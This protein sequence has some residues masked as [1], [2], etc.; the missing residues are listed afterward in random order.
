MSNRYLS[1]PV[2]LEDEYKLPK[3]AALCGSGSRIKSGD[4]R[5]VTC[6]RCMEI[7]KKGGLQL[8]L[9]AKGIKK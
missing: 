4:P 3:W 2:H 6:K 5:D 8:N 1:R 9:Q 7:S